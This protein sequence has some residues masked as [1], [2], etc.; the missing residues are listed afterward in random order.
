MRDWQKSSTCTTTLRIWTLTRGGSQPSS[1]YKKRFRKTFLSVVTH[2]V[3][4]MRP[5]SILEAES[6]C[7][8]KISGFQQGVAVATGFDCGQ[9]YDTLIAVNCIYMK[10][11]KKS[12]RVIT[13]GDPVLSTIF[14][15][16]LDKLRSYISRTCTR[17]SSWVRVLDPRFGNDILRGRDILRNLEI[18]QK[19]E[20]DNDFFWI[21]Q[22]WNNMASTWFIIQITA[23]TMPED[24]VKTEIFDAFLKENSLDGTTEDKINLSYEVQ[25]VVKCAVTH[26]TRSVKMRIVFQ[27]L[28]LL[29]GMFS[30]WKQRPSGVTVSCPWR[31]GWLRINMET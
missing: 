16:L 12:D 11:T 2:R 31:E 7:C 24:D 4:W 18:L 20:T 1:W 29:R 15:K 22:R 28:L 21:V 6:M 19:N 30:L 14:Q 17:W 5:L 26:Q 8:K 25:I 13:D 9:S 10:L 23:E 27:Q 3:T